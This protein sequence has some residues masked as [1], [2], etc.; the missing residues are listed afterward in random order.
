MSLIIIDKIYMTKV[1]NSEVST[2]LPLAI[3][4]LIP[5][6]LGA[7]STHLEDLP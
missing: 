2:D 4:P 6:N 3:D 5:K 7:D 1:L